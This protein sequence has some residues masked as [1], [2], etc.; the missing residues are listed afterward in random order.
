MWVLTQNAPESRA[1]LVNLE[2]GMTIVVH[3][4]GQEMK[5][6]IRLDLDAVRHRILAASY[7]TE[8]AAH[9]ALS[10][11]ATKLSAINLIIHPF[12]LGMEE[13]K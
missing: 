10:A 12:N 4:P 13:A 5:W 8:E 9:Q 7:E 11:L 6:H 3:E 1:H 2:N